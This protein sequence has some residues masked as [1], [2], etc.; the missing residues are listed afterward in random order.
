M[1]LLVTGGAGFIGS[2]FIVEAI[3]RG[4]HVL[5]VDALTYASSLENLGSIESHSAYSFKQIDITDRASVDAAIDAYEPD[6]IVHLAA[7]SHVDRSIE[8]PLNFIQTNILGTYNLLESSRAYWQKNNYLSQFK[9]LHVS[10][11]EVFGSLGDEGL[12]TEDSAYLPNSPYSASKASSDHLVRAWGETYG[13]PVLITNCSN[14]YGPF[15]FPEK[16]IPVTIMSAIAGNKIPIYGSGNNIRDWLYVDD[17][18]DALLSVL[19]KGQSGRTY[20]IGGNTELT[21]LELVQKICSLLDIQK[22]GNKPYVMQVAFVEDRPG[23]DQRYAIDASRIKKE[24]GWKPMT[25]IESG[26]EETISWYLENQ[27][28]MKKLLERDG[29]KPRFGPHS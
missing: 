8:G 15:Q 19:S 23:H 13:L 25:S 26:L 29:V 1:K 24:L 18:V 10:T 17:H 11:D 6:A 2:R 12:F 7:E 5:N 22:P 3:N 28:W 27:S 16:L 14:N 21:N 20:N 4:F 9:F